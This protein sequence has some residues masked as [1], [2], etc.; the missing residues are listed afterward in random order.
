MIT[1]LDVARDQIHR[2]GGRDRALV[3]QRDELAH[4]LA[5]DGKHFYRTEMF[6]PAKDSDEIVTERAVMC[7]G[8]DDFHDPTLSL[9]LSQTN[10]PTGKWVRQPAQN[11][12]L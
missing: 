9:V 8:W 4:E 11:V 1:G 5:G 10:S 3:L 6:V 12:P 7:A 2:H